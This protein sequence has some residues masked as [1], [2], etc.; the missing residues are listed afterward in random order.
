MTIQAFNKSKIKVVFWMNEDGSARV[1]EFVA[2]A[3]PRSNNRDAAWVANEIAEL[4]EC[5]YVACDPVT[6][7]AI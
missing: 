3:N 2:G 6:G 5:G 4:I 7:E 1:D